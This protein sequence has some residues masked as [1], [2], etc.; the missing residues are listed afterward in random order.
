M[1]VMMILMIA[2]DETASTKPM[3]EA[4][5]IFLAVSLSLSTDQSERRKA[6]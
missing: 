3:S 2:Q 1:F 5:M 6:P 4:V